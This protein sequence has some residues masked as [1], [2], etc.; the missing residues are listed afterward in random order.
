[1]RFQGDA[2]KPDATGI[3]FALTDYIELVE[4]SG[5]AIHPN[6]SGFIPEDKP[7]ILKRLKISPEEWIELAE[8]FEDQFSTW[9]G[10]AQ[11]L[12]LLT[13]RRN[14]RHTAGSQR[15]RQVFNAA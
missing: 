11:S 3:P 12:E 5:R 14:I 15:C 9:V 6:K 2:K 7:D 8:K 13:T 1:M 4:W 10:N